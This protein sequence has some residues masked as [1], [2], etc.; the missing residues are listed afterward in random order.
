MVQKTYS[1]EELKD[2]IIKE[3]EEELEKEYKLSN[4]DEKNKKREVEIQKEDDGLKVKII[5]EVKEKI[6]TKAN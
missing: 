4:Y 6:S 5:Y 2:K 3:L 1:E